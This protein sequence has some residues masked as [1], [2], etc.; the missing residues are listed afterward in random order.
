M[1]YLGDW[2]YSVSDAVDGPG[3]RTIKSPA[4]GVAFGLVPVVSAGILPESLVTF[5]AWPRI[6]TN[7]TLLRWLMIK[8]GRAVP[9]LA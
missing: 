3:R 2:S 4:A 6:C 5:R 7:N 8:Y 9:D 1:Q